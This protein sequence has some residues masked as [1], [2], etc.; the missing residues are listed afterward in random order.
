VSAIGR[1]LLRRA[2]IQLPEGEA[3]LWIGR[4]EERAAVR[5]SLR[6]AIVSLA[7]LAVAATGHILDLWSL[8]FGDAGSPARRAL[9]PSVGEI[10]G[11]VIV[12]LLLVVAGSWLWGKWLTSG[13]WYA[14]TNRR[15]LFLHG[16][17]AASVWLG[18]Y[19][20]ITIQIED[21]GDGTGDLLFRRTRSEYDPAAG[22]VG[23]DRPDIF[24][25]V[26]RTLSGAADEQDMDTAFV[27]I[28]N[29]P[30][31]REMILRAYATVR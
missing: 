7:T 28:R 9:T 8:L 6:V 4:P 16:R 25:E 22:R 20:L 29:A 23:S 21:H 30:A 19:D 11:S 5:Y 15:L 24:D 14:V 3:V 18:K 31:V 26:G 10:T 27:G 12:F 2:G 17:K 13:T 1:G